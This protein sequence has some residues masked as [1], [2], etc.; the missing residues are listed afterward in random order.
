M[1]YDFEDSIN[2]IWLRWSVAASLVVEMKCRG[3]FSD[4]YT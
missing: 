2:D 1:G 3:S 4:N